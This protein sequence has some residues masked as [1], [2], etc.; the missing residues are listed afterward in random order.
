MDHHCQVFED[1]VYIH[2][3]RL[4]KAKHTEYVQVLRT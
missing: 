2:D 3:V 4:K 1:L